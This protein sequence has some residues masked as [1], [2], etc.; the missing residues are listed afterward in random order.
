[1]KGNTVRIDDDSVSLTH[2]RITRKDGEFLLKDLNSTNGTTINGQPIHEAI[3][4]DRDYVRFANVPSHFVVDDSQVV[5]APA[6]PASEAA[7]STSAYPPVPMPAA[8]VPPP[9]APAPAPVQLA[10]AAAPPTVSRLSSPNRSAAASPRGA[11]RSISVSGLVGVLGG[12]VAIG[13]VSGILWMMVHRAEAPAQGLAANGPAAS[14][15]L[16]GDSKRLPPPGVIPARSAPAAPDAA[17]KPAIDTTINVDAES[18]P[19]TIKNLSSADVAERRRA[20]ASLHSMGPAAKDAMPALRAALKDSDEEV[21]LWS[22]LSLVNNQ[23]YDK[24]A[25]PIL[26]GALQREDAMLRQVACLSLALIPYE[27]AEKEPVVSALTNLAVGD[28]DEEVRQAAMSALNI[29]APDV[30][31]KVGK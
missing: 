6:L 12:A 8:A 5:M 14:Q 2:A 27:P 21:Q 23:S 25:V 30:L 3:L 11:K 28:A 17:P 1:M 9:P 4:R 7:A 24:A 22:A 19:E 13:V 18:L 10:G 15:Q 29:V 31:A 20:A 26:V 16:R